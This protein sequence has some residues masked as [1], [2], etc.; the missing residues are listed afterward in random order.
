MNKAELDR[1]IART[2][3]GRQRM[4][5]LRKGWEMADANKDY[6]GQMHYRLE[7]V[8]DAVF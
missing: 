1:E 6:N 3:N 2:P 7:Y 4:E 5:L 8:H